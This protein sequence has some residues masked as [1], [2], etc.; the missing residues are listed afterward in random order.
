MFAVGDIVIRT[1][2]SDMERCLHKGDI[3]VVTEVIRLHSDPTQG[4]VKLFG[5]SGIWNASHFELLPLASVPVI[6]EVSSSDYMLDTVLDEEDK[7][8]I[9]EA[10]CLM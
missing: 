9:G 7:R 3:R 4:Y 8:V 5:A 10:L 1:G 2:P 6:M